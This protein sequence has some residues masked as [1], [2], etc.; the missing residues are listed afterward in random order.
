MFCQQE[1]CRQARIEYAEETRKAQELQDKIKAE[2]AEAKYNKHY[3]ICWEVG[4]WGAET[5]KS[6]DDFAFL[7]LRLIFVRRSVGRFSLITQSLSLSV[8]QSLD[9]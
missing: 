5:M 4:C 1:L 7:I 6:I 2:I 9:Q 3:G 8:A